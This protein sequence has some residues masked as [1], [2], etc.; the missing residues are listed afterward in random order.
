MYDID[1][2]GKESWPNLPNHCWDETDRRELID[3]PVSDDWL[4]HFHSLGMTPRQPD[5]N[6]QAQINELNTKL[7][8]IEAMTQSMAE[9]IR[10]TG[11]LRGPSAVVERKEA[12][13]AKKKRKGSKR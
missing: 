3:F 4:A 8:S 9:R 12:A 1:D 5:P 13:A 6:V 10:K 2:V 11:Y 7:Q